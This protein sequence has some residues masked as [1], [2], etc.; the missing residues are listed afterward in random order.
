MNA[1]IDTIINPIMLLLFSAGAFLFIWGLVEFLW[2]VDTEKGQETG[3][4]H[5]LWG[6][7]GMFIMA[8]VFGIIS[9]ITSTLGV[10]FPPRIR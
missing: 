5:M 4:Q 6:L 1:I 8:T 3:R 9:L 10:E 2:K 7:V